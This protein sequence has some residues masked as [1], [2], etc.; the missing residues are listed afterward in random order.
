MSDLYPPGFYSGSSRNV[1]MN[2]SS[3]PQTHNS[4]FMTVFII[5]VLIT[6]VYIMVVFARKHKKKGE[7]KNE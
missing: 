3:V 1:T 6:Y 4:L 5:L 2:I 7:K